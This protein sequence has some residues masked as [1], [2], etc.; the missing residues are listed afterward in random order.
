MFSIADHTYMTLALRLAAQGLYSTTPNPR[1]GCVIV[2]NQQIIGQGAH[3]KAGEAHAEIHALQAAGEAARGAD[4]YV[5]LEPCSHVGR[6]PP[7]MDALI[8]AGVKRVVVAMQKLSK[9][10]S[11]NGVAG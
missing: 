11:T 8:K 7:C 10:D 5:T 6:T 4:V 1:V 3:L 9:G 2:K